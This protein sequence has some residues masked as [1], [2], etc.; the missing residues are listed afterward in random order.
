[1]LVPGQPLAASLLF[2]AEA[3]RDAILVVRCL[4]GE[5]LRLLDGPPEPGLLDARLGWWQGALAGQAEHP[6]LSA[7]ATVV[8]SRSVPVQAASPLLSGLARA[9]HGARFE[10]FEE[11]WS[12]CRALGGETAALEY[13]LHSSGTD[14]LEAALELGAAGWLL[15]RVRDIPRDAQYNR[16]LVPLDLQAQFQVARQDVIDGRDG[17]GW[18][19]L[20]QTLVSR[21]VQRGN[22]AA[23]EL[24]PKHRHLCLHWAVERRLAAALAGRP[25]AMFNRRVLPG[26]AGNVWTAWRAAR[27]LTPA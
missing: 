27:R 18:R 17:P 19:G 12:Q 14:G 1:M 24:G 2:A 23:I 25:Q 3:D 7:W 21:A 8:A 22:A 6:A 13:R 11:L 4:A 9:G 20:V 10:R 16:W 26:H 15:K 5:L